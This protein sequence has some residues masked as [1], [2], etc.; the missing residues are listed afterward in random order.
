MLLVGEL[1]LVFALVSVSTPLFIFLSVLF[2]EL[3]VFLVAFWLM[4]FMSDLYSTYRFY[5][6]DPDQ[7]KYRERNRIFS[8]LAENL[9]FRKASIVFPLLFEVPMIFFFAFLLL[10]IVYTYMFNSSTADPSACLAA[11]FAV[12]GV[13]HVQAALSNFRLKV[14]PRG[15]GSDG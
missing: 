12:S 2:P 10:Q 1:L 7:F 14:S 13:G 11:S 4:A 15:G 6:E 5:R 8:L 3:R 9:D